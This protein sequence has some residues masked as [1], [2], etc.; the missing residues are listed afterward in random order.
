MP[1]VLDLNQGIITKQFFTNGLSAA[2][3]DTNSFNN[4]VVTIPVRAASIGL[5]AA[6]NPTKFRYRVL[7]FDRQSQNVV[8]DTLWLTYD[9]ARPGLDAQGGNLDPF[10]YDDLPTTTIPVVFD[11][12]N[13]DTNGSR[14]LIL[15]HMHNFTGARTDVITFA[16]PATLTSA[17]SRK[18]HG[19]AGI[20]DLP[21]SLVATNPTIEPRL[22]PAHSIA[23]T[24]DKPVTDATVAV[25][26]GTAIVATP[27]FS[28]N[29]VMV[30]LS[31]VDDQQ[32]VTVSVTNVTS[33]DGGTGGS[34]SVRVGFLSGDVNGNRV[35]TLADLGM[36]N[37]QL[38]QPVTASNYLKDVNVSGTL[39]LADKGMVNTKLTHALPAP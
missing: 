18:A 31:G 4:S 25:T 28:G 38:A 30:N 9:I 19:A 33:A 21:L 22:G 7:T 37:A 29:D 5:G 23:L 27:T 10:F 1:V 13:Y 14:G 26:E 35:V 32:Y 16:T 6:G 8:D 17:A 12:A 20:F 39:S 24:F 2:T 36:V 34:G 15:A 11:A 3:R